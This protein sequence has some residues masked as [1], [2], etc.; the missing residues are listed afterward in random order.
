MTPR[1]V[2][3]AIRELVAAAEEQGWDVIPDLK[4][5][6]DAGR[7]AYADLQIVIADAVDHEVAS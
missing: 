2:L 4:P 6:L 5:V 7:E 3:D 1:E